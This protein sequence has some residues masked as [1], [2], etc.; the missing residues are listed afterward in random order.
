M[1]LACK[2]SFEL[3]QPVSIKDIA[4]FFLQWNLSCIAVSIF[5]YILFCL[6]DGYFC[7]FGDDFNNDV[8]RVAFC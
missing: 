6:V 2:N 7:I 1:S 4:V 5:I 8:T 3:L